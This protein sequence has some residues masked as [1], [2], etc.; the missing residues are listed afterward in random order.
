MPQL[1]TFISSSH[2]PEIKGGRLDKSH[3]P[4]VE[5]DY[6]IESNMPE[7]AINTIAFG[8]KPD[9]VLLSLEH[10][11]DEEDN[12][13]I[14][15][16]EDLH[17]RWT[18]VQNNSESYFIYR[19]N[20]VDQLK[21]YPRNL[22]VRGCQIDRGN[23]YWRMLGEFFNFVDTW[24][25]RVICAP[26]QQQNNESKLYQ[27]N[28]SLKKAS[29]CYDN[30]SIG[31]S[32]VIKGRDGLA[33]LANDKRYIVKSLSGIRSIVVD[34]TDFTS[35]NQANLS[36]LPTL[37]QEKVEGHDLRVHVVND[38]V[39]GKLSLEKSSVD[40]RYDDNFFS[41]VD[42]EDFTD[43]LKSFCL[44]VTENEEN[45]FMGIDFIK[46]ENGYVVLEANPSPG[47]SAYHECNGI[48]NDDFIKDLLVELTH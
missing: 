32:Y 24:K 20:D 10:A 46:S 40:Y 12:I 29:N 2:R 25:G 42:Y 33:K 13:F 34:N 7:V 21:I 15:Y 3:H 22:Y 27:L 41:L 37:F 1:K 36:S 48:E 39:Y 4:R 16:Y 35:W 14:F 38:K 43:S 30:I 47:W 23:P 5:I 8:P 26:K 18:Y 45:S 6:S 17:K 31:K 19:K 44:A 9:K 11:I 28:S